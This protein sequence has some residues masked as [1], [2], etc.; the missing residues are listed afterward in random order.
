MIVLIAPRKI[1]PGRLTYL[2]TF[3][4][5]IILEPTLIA[6]EASY[7]YHQLV[8]TMS[9][10][11]V[12]YSFSLALGTLP[13]DSHDAFYNLGEIGNSITCKI[14]GGAL[15]WG[16]I[17]NLFLSCSLSTCEYASLSLLT[18]C[19]LQCKESG[20]AKIRKWLIGVPI[21]Y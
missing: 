13:M 3:A 7:L 20:L 1:F 8:G 21:V 14:Q 2:I 12:I 10:F 18:C 5:C 15:H 6:S 19:R 4:R 17:T 11:D 16:G 9:A